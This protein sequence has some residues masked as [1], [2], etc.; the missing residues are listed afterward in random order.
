MERFTFL[1]VAV[2]VLAAATP[3]AA[4][5]PNAFAP[6]YAAPTPV[7]TGESEAACIRRQMQITDPVSKIHIQEGDARR[8]CSRSRN[9]R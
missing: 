4:R 1:G 2:L 3:A 7:Q 6:T 9:R 5:S 8:F